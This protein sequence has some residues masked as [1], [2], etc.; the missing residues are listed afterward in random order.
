MSVFPKITIV[1]PNYNYGH[2]LE[3]TILSVISQNYPNLEYIIIDGGSTDNSLEIIRKYE[4]HFSFWCSEKDGGMYNGINKGFDKSSG[5]I[6]AWINSD[7]VYF[8]WALQTVAEIFS[9]FKH[10]QWISSLQ[11]GLM[12]YHGKIL[13]FGHIRGFSQLA[14]AEDMYG[15]NK[16]GYGA[17]QQESTFWSRTLWN[18]TGSE[19]SELYQMAGDYELWSRFF[20]LEMLYGIISPLGCYRIQDEQKTNKGQQYTE[21][22][23]EIMMS[24]RSGLTPERL[25]RAS[26]RKTRASVIPG[27]GWRLARL[28]GYNSV[29]ITRKNANSP[30]SEWKEEKAFF[31]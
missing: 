29:N 23:K 1:T 3:Q 17:I 5:E 14:F 31:L 30:K 28:A 7:D 16:N 22:C 10:V 15:I 24:Y 13:D 25:F 21:E 19:L 2:F 20:K 8:P 18:Q 26:L 4:K 11:P 12:D 6:M 27:L 9:T